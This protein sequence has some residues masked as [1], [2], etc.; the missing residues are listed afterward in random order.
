MIVAGKMGALWDWIVAG[1]DVEA[2][3]HR[4]SRTS[5]VPADVTHAKLEILIGNRLIYPDGSLAKGAKAALNVITARKLGIKQIHAASLAQ[6][7]KK[8]D[9]RGN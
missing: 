4:V 1:W 2:M 5:G 9:D 7:R 8:D 3:A 6:P